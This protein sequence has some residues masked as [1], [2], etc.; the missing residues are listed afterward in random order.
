[1]NNTGLKFI[2]RALQHRNYRLF[3]FGQ[4]VSLVGTWMQ[5]IAV[6]WLVYR[7]T[8]SAILLGIVGFA[9]QISAF[10]FVPFSGVMIDRWDKRRLLL[11]TQILSMIQAFILAFL[12]LNGSIQVW[13]IIGLSLLLGLVNA[14]DMPARQSF[15]VEMLEKKDD[16]GNAIAL[17]S[18]IFNGARL[19]GPAVA[20]II[21]A[22][23]GEGICF[24]INGLSFIAVI[25]ALTRMKIKPG[26]ERSQGNH[27]LHDLREGIKYTFGSLPIRQILLLFSLVNLTGISYSVLMPVFAKEIL[28]GGPKTLGT[29]MGAIGL[30]ALVGA[31]FVASRKEVSK[32]F[33]LINPAMII[34]G[35]GLIAFSFSRSLILSLVLLSFTGFGVMIQISSSNTAL[36]LLTEDDKRGRVMGFYTMAFVGMATFGSLLT[37]WL[38]SKIGA[39]HTLLISGVSCIAGALL[40]YRKKAFLGLQS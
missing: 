2:L 3:F 32:V 6:S 16:L 18:L 11:I 19:L 33:K 10:L 8:H 40:F 30:G 5:T 24:L 23:F 14:F 27:I 28:G 7:L 36:Q 21:I 17:N 35:C 22:G 39:P 34:I 12:A 15:V 31:L 38:A 26:F 25:L 20:G 29:L 4:G 37:G 1:M 9:G 13:Q